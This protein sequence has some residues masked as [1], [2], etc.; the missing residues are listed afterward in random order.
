MAY[1]AEA[2]APAMRVEVKVVTTVSCMAT[3]VKW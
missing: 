1:L 2:M 3:V